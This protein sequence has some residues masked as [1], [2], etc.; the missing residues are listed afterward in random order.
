MKS[1]EAKIELR[2]V[3]YKLF[4]EGNRPDSD[5]VKALV[6]H[7]GARNLYYG[8][9]KQSGKPKDYEQKSYERGKATETKEGIVTGFAGALPEPRGGNEQPVQTQET[10]DKPQVEAEQPK[11]ESDEE[12]PPDDHKEKS[13]NLIPA[14]GEVDNETFPGL[15]IAGETLPFKVQ[16]SV[17]T[18]ALYEIAATEAGDSLSLGKFL[19]TCARD[20]FLGRGVDLGLVELGGSRHG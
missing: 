1:D 20:Y 6:P 13:D 7:A 17:K 9:W 11:G 16:L 10:A 14:F 2:S 15:K 19:D 5:K 18:I 8:T 4:A 3:V 12:A